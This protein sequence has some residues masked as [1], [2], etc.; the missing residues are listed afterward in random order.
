MACMTLDGYIARLDRKA[1]NQESAGGWTSAE[2]KREFWREVEGSDVIVAGRATLN[3]MPPTKKRTVLMTRH[4]EQPLDAPVDVDWTLDPYPSTVHDFLEGFHDK[5]LLV[6]GGSR[7]YDFFLRWNLVD[8]LI[9]IIEPLLFR[10][11]VNLTTPPAFRGGQEENKFSLLKCRPVNARGTLRM[12][13]ER[14]KVW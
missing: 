10:E 2:D 4:A 12:D 7:T 5:R 14:A 6:C 13:L 9:L 11:G 8:H 1:P 3:T